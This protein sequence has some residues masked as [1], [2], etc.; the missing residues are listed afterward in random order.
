MNIFL[1]LTYVKTCLSNICSLK[2]YFKIDIKINCA[3]T[4]Y[5]K[6]Y[7]NFWRN[8][9]MIFIKFLGNIEI[10]KIVENMQQFIPTLVSSI[11]TD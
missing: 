7:Y 2:K 8:Y 11:F 4:I 1:T 6:N 9:E 3:V 10:I 5:K